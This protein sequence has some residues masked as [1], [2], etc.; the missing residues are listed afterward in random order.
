MEGG[1]RVGQGAA[2]R[3]REQATDGSG[4]REGAARRWWEEARA[5]HRL[6]LVVRHRRSGKS[7]GR[8]LRRRWGRDGGPAAVG[9]AGV[10]WWE[11]IGGGVAGVGWVGDKCMTCGSYCG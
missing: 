5:E 11:R 9:P 4:D 6:D 2:R 8:R 10:K 3:R 7:G 1:R